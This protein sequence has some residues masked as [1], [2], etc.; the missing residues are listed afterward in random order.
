MLEPVKQCTQK[1]AP[2]GYWIDAKSCLTPEKLIGDV[3]KLRDSLVYEIAQAALK[4]NRLLSQFNAKSFTDIQAF[5]DLSLERYGVVSGGQ[6]GNIKMTTFDGEFMVKRSMHDRISFDE[7][8]QAARQ[9]IDDCLK[10]WTNGAKP[11]IHAVIQQAFNTDKEGKINIGEIL[12]LRRLNIDDERWNMAMRAIGEAITVIDTKRYLQ[13]YQRN[14][15]T[16]AYELISLNLA[17]MQP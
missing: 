2:E 4:L 9:L 7:K 6:K 3:D 13:V 8:L 5:I 12:K 11:E 14:A 1:D 15:T 10:D 16:N 17:K